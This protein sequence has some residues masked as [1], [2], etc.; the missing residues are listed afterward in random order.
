MKN[1]SQEF[2][3][4]H[5]KIDQKV[6]EKIAVEKEIDE[7]KRQAVDLKLLPFKI[8]DEV[9]ALIKLGRAHKKVRCVLEYSD[10]RAYLRPYT[11]EGELSKVRSTLI[12]FSKY[13]SDFNAKELLEE[14][15]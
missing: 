14:V 12:S 4:I 11:K 2:L 10:G 9:F 3:N 6:R 15:K 7:L 8:G 13:E 5:E 1:M